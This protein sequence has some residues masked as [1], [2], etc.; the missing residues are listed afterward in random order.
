MAIYKRY[1]TRKKKIN[2]P[3]IIWACCILLVFAVTVAVGAYLGKAAEGGVSYVTGDA[4]SEGDG[5]TLASVIPHIM[6]AVYVEPD[7]LADFTAEDTT[8]YASTWI[9]RDGESCFAT[10]VEKALGKDTKKK[11]LLGSLAISSPVSGMFEVGSLYSAE[12]VRGIL[13]EYEKAVLSE[14]SASGPDEVVLVFNELTE[15]NYSD[16]IS[17]AGELCGGVISV[18]YEALYEGFFVR[19][20]SLASENGFTTALMADRVSPEQLA[21]DIEDYA[22]YFTRDFMRLMISGKD[23]ALAD[24][25]REKNVLNYQ[26][27]S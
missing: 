13:A 8:L 5:E 14:L 22:V 26:F 2:Y 24:V 19:F 3:L 18:P 12:N 9:F 17:L 15:E 16:V 6:Q 10:E 7:K 20:L 27:Y 25:L 21:T 4:S 11:P 1:N 23:A